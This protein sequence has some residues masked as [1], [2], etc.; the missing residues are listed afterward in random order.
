MA[1]YDH[2]A[3]MRKKECAEKYEE[4]KKFITSKDEQGKLS[5]WLLASEH[6]RDKENELLE[7]TKKI[8]EYQKFFSLLRGLLPREFSIHDTIG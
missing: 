8:E 4:L 7:K 5:E 1:Y 6:I 2:G 3:A